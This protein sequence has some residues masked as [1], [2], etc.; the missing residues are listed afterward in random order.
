MF[1]ILVEMIEDILLFQ[2][3]IVFEVF[4]ICV[5][6]VDGVLVVFLKGGKGLYSYIWSNGSIIEIFVELSVGLY[7]LIVIDV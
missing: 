5:G 3:I 6:V 1:F 4:I 7:V 2:V